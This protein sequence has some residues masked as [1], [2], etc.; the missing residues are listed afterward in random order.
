MT[1]AV[2]VTAPA[3]V[4]RRPA[5]DVSRRAGSWAGQLAALLMV[6]GAVDWRR[7]A[8]FSGAVDPVVLGKALVAGFGLLLA[9]G[10][11]SA[12]RR[13]RLGTLSMWL[14]AIVLGSSVWGALTADQLL[15]GG[16]MAVRVA[17]LG[18]TVFFL[19]RAAPALQV[20]RQVARACGAIAVIASLT[21]LPGMTEGRLAGGLPAMDPNA[22][23]LLAGIPLVFLAWRTVLGEAGWGIA[24]GGGWFLA[25]LW[26]TGSRT[27]LLMLLV[28]VAGMAVHVRRPR[29][30]LVVG[31]LVF[32]ALAV[33]AA[34][35]TGFLAGFAARGGDGTS[36][37]GSRFIA[38]RAAADWAGSTWQT[39]FGGGLNVKVIPVTGQYWKT[40]PLDSSWA[41]LLVQTGLLG[42]LVAAAWVCW[43]V[44][45]ALRA[46][47]PHRV[48][49]LGLG[50]FLVGRSLLES[51]LFD[52]SP[53]FLL[54]LA[55]SLLAEGA[56]R[57]R[58][59][60]EAA[61][62]PD[63]GPPAPARTAHG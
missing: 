24:A 11:A 57:Q 4:H 56:T 36:T 42:L 25:V 10:L 26:L 23:A 60:D 58:L 18:G 59:R 6:L 17:V 31:G 48:L 45:G 53:A 29:V 7:G 21:G 14:L 1:A 38:W 19:L 47:H 34:V 12:G 62:L 39:V 27:A 30:G 16:V 35:G 41:S 63:G 15:G 54:F 61:G 3:A 52:A 37:L 43:V 22:L 8:Y 50:V 51:G 44:R 13:Y 32:A 33:V 5:G 40:Q 55:V 20:L 28:A 46:P 49:F 2:P 9:L